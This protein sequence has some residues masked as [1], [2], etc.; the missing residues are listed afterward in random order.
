MDTWGQKHFK[1]RSNNVVTSFYKTLCKSRTKFRRAA[2]SCPRKILSVQS[3]RTVPLSGSY[4]TAT[5]RQYCTRW[6]TKEQTRLPRCTRTHSPSRQVS[7]YQPNKQASKH[8]RSGR[9]T[10]TFFRA[11]WYSKQISWA[12]MPGKARECLDLVLWPPPLHSK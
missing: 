12:T 7:N 5:G 6:P 9:R 4:L 2:R 10:G 11:R 8:S 3:I 1:R